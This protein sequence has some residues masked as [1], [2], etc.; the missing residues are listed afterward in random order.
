M[1]IVFL[2]VIVST[3]YTSPQTHF[4]VYIKYIQIFT[5]QPYFNEVF[6]VFFFKDSKKKKCCSVYLPSSNT[7]FFFF[8]PWETIPDLRKLYLTLIRDLWTYDCCPLDSDLPSRALEV[9]PSSTGRPLENQ[10]V[11]VSR[12]SSSDSSKIFSYVIV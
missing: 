9:S 5:C 10:L 6:F 7:W 1:S 4:V 2:V 11:R 12:R 8:A 3:L